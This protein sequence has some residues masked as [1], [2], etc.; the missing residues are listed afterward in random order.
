MSQFAN[1]KKES[2]AAASADS[3]KEWKVP[4]RCQTLLADVK[5]QTAKDSLIKQ[6]RMWKQQFHMMEEKAAHAE[7]EVRRQRASKQIS[8]R[9]ERN[10][11]DARKEML[12]AIWEFPKIRG[13]LFG[14]LIIRI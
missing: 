5:L 6:A 2:L 3:A 12:S 10:A 13:T 7:V 1:K 8:R 4:R 11:I 9:Q 14:V